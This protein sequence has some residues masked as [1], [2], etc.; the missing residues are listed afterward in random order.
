[1]RDIGVFIESISIGF[2]LILFLFVF[3]Y[4][5]GKIVL[6][7]FATKYGRDSSAAAFLLPI[8]GISVIVMGYAIIVTRLH[9]FYTYFLILGIS[10]LIYRL[11]ENRKTLIPGKK[12]IS[13]F[14]DPDFWESFKTDFKLFFLINI[15]SCIC[16]YVT[17][18]NCMMGS[19]F[20]FYPDNIFH[21]EV[22]K[23]IGFTGTENFY[24]AFFQY[25]VTR[26]PNLYH[27]F[28]LYL[29][30]IIYFC[31]GKK[32]D[33]LRALIFVAYPFFL[34]IFILGFYRIATK[35]IHGTKIK[36]FYL[37]I[38]SVFSWA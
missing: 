17:A 36:K 34:D 23:G 10:Y 7:F 31:S 33:D 22:A 5:V 11:A 24:N 19:F 32:I 4:M 18:Y 15:F 12:Y 38:L 27:F 14:S 13:G 3:S 26:K 37:L 29:S 6:P 8:C 2:V 30:Q 20:Y 16:A 21:S 9:T 28:E 35:I 25:Y 1:M